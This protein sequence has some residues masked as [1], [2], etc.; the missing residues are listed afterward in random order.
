MIEQ[1]WAQEAGIQIRVEHLGHGHVRVSILEAE[2]S[3]QDKVLATA[4]L[5]PWRWERV[6]SK[7]GAAIAAQ[8]PQDSDANK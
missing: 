5:T 8:T 1:V 3:G 4:T 2:V 7:M 6:V